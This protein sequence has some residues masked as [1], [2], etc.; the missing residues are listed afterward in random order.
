MGATVSGRKAALVLLAIVV[1]VVGLFAG[2]A[3]WNI[4]KIRTS[5]AIR[6]YEK[7]VLKTAGGEMVIVP[8]GEYQVPPGQAAPALKAFYIDKRAAAA[9][10]L[11]CE[12]QGKRL[13]TAA[14]LAKAARGATAEDDVSIYGAMGLA[15]SPGSRCAVDAAGR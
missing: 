8:A 3:L 11:S 14:E 4:D 15:R 1:G 9:D 6:R 10:A 5:V 2:L 7:P 13:A 12:A